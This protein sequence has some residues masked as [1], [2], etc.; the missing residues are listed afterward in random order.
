MTDVRQW[1]LDRNINP[2]LALKAGV[3]Y[4]PKRDAILYP[5]VGMDHM[6]YGW[7]VRHLKDNKVYNDHSGVSVNDCE[8]FTVMDGGS[9]TLC[10]C[11]G[12]T[13]A[14]ALAS[15]IEW[16]PEF[17]DARIIAVPGA[18]VFP[19]AWAGMFKDYD[20]VYL[21]PDPDDAGE[22]MVNRVCGLMARTKVVKLNPE[23]GDLNDHICKQLGYLF[24]AV[25]AAQPVRVTQKLRRTNYDF[26][27]SH[28]FPNHI[29]VDEAARDTKLKRR[30]KEYYGVCPLHEDSD[31]SF[32]VDPKKGVFWCYG[33]EQ[34]GDIISYLQARDGLTFKEALRAAKSLR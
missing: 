20:D 25:P 28:D 14:L 5:R 11:E 17:T 16:F 13:D 4:D 19:N 29:I 22:H 30:G 34:G 8:P 3:R 15:N 1:F 9:N 21:F 24:D 33:C 7:K 26:K 10:I 6:P 23:Y 32:S 12:E 2:D 31:P 27:R 18:N